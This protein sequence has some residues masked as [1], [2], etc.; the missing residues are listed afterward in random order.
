MWLFPLP[1]S[2]HFGKACPKHRGM[3][4]ITVARWRNTAHGSTSSNV[5][6]AVQRVMFLGRLATTSGSCQAK[7]LGDLRLPRRCSCQTCLHRWKGWFLARLPP[8][9]EFAMTGIFLP[10]N[11]KPT[12]IICIL[13]CPRCLSHPLVNDWDTNAPICSARAVGSLPRPTIRWAV[14]PW[15][16]ACGTSG[17]GWGVA[18][19]GPTP[20]L[21]Q[22]CPRSRHDSEHTVNFPIDPSGEW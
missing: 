8:D 6:N 21:R 10:D 2:A 13:R 1:I 12:L 17:T 19:P 9:L 16:W 4:F 3:L 7:G 18:G 22:S 5:T 11:S 15:D 14:S 20:Q